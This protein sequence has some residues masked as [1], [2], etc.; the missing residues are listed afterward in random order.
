MYLLPVIATLLCSS[1][2]RVMLHLT[3][4]LFFV[5]S[6]LCQ[7]PSLWWY[8]DNHTLYSWITRVATIGY[9][10]IGLNPK[11]HGYI[12][13]PNYWDGYHIGCRMIHGYPWII[14]GYTISELLGWLPHWMSDD[15]WISMDNPW[16]HCIS[17]L[18]H[19][20]ATTL[21]VGWSM[22]Y[23]WIHCISELLGWLPHWMSDDP[24]G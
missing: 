9:L 6:I 7:C 1:R 21:D 15:S 22:D 10:D 18:L 8:I 20:M 5:V 13:F 24:N 12:V 16:I 14:H 11:I 23:P 3:E 17:E 4:I 19:W 2:T